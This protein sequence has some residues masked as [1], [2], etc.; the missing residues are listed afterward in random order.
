MSISDT[1]MQGTVWGSLLCPSTVDSLGKK[2]Y[3]HKENLYMYKGV[4]ILPLCMVDDIISVANVKQTEN[5]NNL[6]YT[7]IESKNLKLSQ[8]KCFQFHI[9]KGHRACPKLQVH[10]NDMKEVDYE[11]Y[12]DD[13]IDKTGRIQ[14]IINSRKPKGQGINSKNTIYYR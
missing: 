1:I 12:L 4:P 14:T 13:V 6:I 11:K 2:C 3:E 5:I 7:F 8:T 9:G 10:N